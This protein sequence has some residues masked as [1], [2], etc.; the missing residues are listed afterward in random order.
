MANELYWIN[1]C[2]MQAL[3]SVSDKT[4]L[5]NLATA[6]SDSGFSLISTG[7]TYR[8]LI[9]AGLTAQQISELTNFPEILDGRVKTLHPKIHG[10]ILARR[11]LPNH[12]KEL[13]EHDIEAIDLVIV[14]LYP[15]VETV[16]RNNASL[17]EALENIDIGGPTLLRAA[18]KNFPSVIVIVDPGDYCWISERLRNGFLP[19]HQTKLLSM[20]E[21][22]ELARKAF[23]H[24]ALYDTT[25]ARY[26]G[27]DAS[28]SGRDLTF[29]Y[30]KQY[31]LRYGENPHQTASLY[32][33]LLSSTGI[34]NAIQLHG[35]QLSY[36]NLLDA[37]AAWRAVSDFDESVV[38][39]IK[40]TN[41]CGL[42]LH[43][44]QSIA[45][46]RAFDGDPVS[47]YGG[48]VGFNAKVSV[49]TVNAMRDIFYEVV[50]AP[51]YETEALDILKQRKNLR[52][53]KVTPSIRTQP[54]KEV[55]LITGGAVV[56]DADVA[57][58][59]AVS[60]EVVTTRQ[61]DDQE[62][63][64]LA[65]AWKVA[66]HVKSNAIVLAKN[67]AVTGIGAGQPNRV[68]SVYLSLKG[69]G[70][71]GKGSVLASDA[72]FPFADNI[73]AAA[74]GGVASIV[75]PGGSIRD[76]EVIDAANAADISMVFTG[77]RHFKH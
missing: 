69:A 6:A 26:L 12:E 30:R 7:G 76:Q 3:I 74:L 45:Y 27:F 55:R 57:K 77:T 28:D 22:R 39:I 42:A 61:V 20:D 40:H 51:E 1:F 13:R 18:A 35:K 67:R 53:L 56:Q 66:K 43:S 34:A 19:N 64:D 24:V 63:S 16:T 62:L 75:Q 25:I 36:N 4:G 73:Q 33:D 54:E 2:N 52:I 41:P 65:F 29:G 8:E 44:D 60:W 15:F 5:I 23:Q 58:D 21:R 47:A 11:D 70:E 50:L 32:S 10:G 31:D 71:N 9:Q 46:Q 38:V 59:D 17:E 37:D 72:F 68:N 49:D 14:N 48:I